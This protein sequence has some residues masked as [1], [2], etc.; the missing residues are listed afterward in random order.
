MIAAGAGL[1]AQLLLAGRRGPAPSRIARRRR[2]GSETSPEVPEGDDRLGAR[3]RPL[4]PAAARLR[5]RDRQGRGEDDRR[6]LPERDRARQPRDPPRRGARPL[7]RPAL[8]PRGQRGRHGDGDPL[9]G[10]Q[11]E[12][13]PAE[14]LLTSPACRMRMPSSSGSRA[15]RRT[16]R[17]RPRTSTRTAPRRPGSGGASRRRTR[18][19]A[20]A[21]RPRTPRTSGW[22]APQPRQ[23]AV[24]CPSTLRRSSRSQSAALP[25]TA[26]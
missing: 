7:P 17:S 18:A 20:R 8:Q 3:R 19:R 11:A 10:D 15:A 24:Q 13:R 6:A 12:S 25:T 14:P 23:N 26:A 22:A 16:P 4:Q 1:R 9:L 21:P 2:S 5:R